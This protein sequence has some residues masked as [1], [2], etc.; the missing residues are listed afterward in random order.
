MNLRLVELS[1]D[2]ARALKS[3]LRVLWSRDIFGIITTDK[4]PVKVTERL[5]AVS[6]EWN[7]LLS[8]VEVFL[9]HVATVGMLT[10]NDDLLAKYKKAL[11]FEVLQRDL[12]HFTAADFDTYIV[13]LKVR[14]AAIRRSFLD[15]G[16]MAP[17]EYAATQNPSV[18]KN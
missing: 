7:L 3:I 16:M 12:P 1:A 4:N 9:D 14:W 11:E 2:D 6:D 5:M 8:P 17:E 10:M 18:Y 13:P 15:A